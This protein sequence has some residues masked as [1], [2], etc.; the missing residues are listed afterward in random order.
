[1]LPYIQSTQLWLHIPSGVA[2]D[3]ILH[4][5]C[6][7]NT[8]SFEGSIQL[9]FILIP[10]A[11]ILIPPE[12]SNPYLTE[13]RRKKHVSNTI[14]KRIQSIQRHTEGWLV[15]ESMYRYYDQSKLKSGG[16][17][18]LNVKGINTGLQLDHLMEVDTPY[19]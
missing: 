2:Q 8:S 18:L 5:T 6:H 14:R 12:N 7:V 16:T 3:P 4:N 9:F 19:I 15:N 1:M 10:I 17:C 13:M 11:G